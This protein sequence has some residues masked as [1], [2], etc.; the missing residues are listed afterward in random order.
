[1]GLALLYRL[2]EGQLPR[3]EFPA[4]RRGTLIVVDL[5]FFDDGIELRVG[6]SS[7]LGLA[8][9]MAA[10]A[11]HDAADFASGSQSAVGSAQ[12]TGFRSRWPTG[13]DLTFVA[14]L[15]SATGVLEN[16]H[17]DT[18]VAGTVRARQ[19]LQ[20]AAS[21]LDRIV[22]AH[23]ASMLEGEDLVQGPLG[24][25]RT[26]GRLGRFGQFGWDSKLSVVPSTTVAHKRTR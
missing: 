3:G 11:F 20:S 15:E 17:L 26:T 8:Y 12:G 10:Q 18:G 4:N 6:Q 1:M 9:A 22:P 5:R 16:F 19:Q 13:N 2:P 21:V 25:P 14:H 23:L 7:G 24:A